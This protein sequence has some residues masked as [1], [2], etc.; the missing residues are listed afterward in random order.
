MDGCYES[1][2]SLILP[3]VPLTPPPF[4]HTQV[5]YETFRTVEE[6][7]TAI[8]E[9][10]ESMTNIINVKFKRDGEAASVAPTA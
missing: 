3:L 6:M 1:L 2:S 7:T 8:V 9:K 5:D 4:N 10:Y